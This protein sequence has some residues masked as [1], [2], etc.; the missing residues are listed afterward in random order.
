MYAEIKNYIEKNLSHLRFEHLLATAKECSYLCQMFGLDSNA[1][2][3]AGI[4]HD[5]ARELP[6]KEI[7][8]LVERD[9]MDISD[10]E[11]KHPVLLH[12]RAGAVFLREEFGINEEVIL[13]A[14][15]WHTV[16]HPDMGSLGKVLFVADYIEPERDHITEDYRRKVHGLN[17]N[18]MVLAVLSR[19]IEY[20]RN[21]GNII[22][23]SSILLYDKLLSEND[24]KRAG[25]G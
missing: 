2:R 22:A 14:V 7:V 17:L 8:A 16:G 24:R 19:Q 1:G 5:I 13:E 11:Y 20:L 12:G 10:Y 9:G 3:I 15:R 4:S 6:E 25:I 21:R 18:G 23:E